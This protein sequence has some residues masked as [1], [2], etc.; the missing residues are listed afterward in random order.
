M[1]MRTRRWLIQILL[2]NQTKISV[3]SEISTMRTTVS[4]VCNS[5]GSTG[6]LTWG[7]CLIYEI[8]QPLHDVPDRFIIDRSSRPMRQPLSCYYF[9]QVGCRCCAAQGGCKAIR[10]LVEK[11]NS[12][13]SRYVLTKS[14]GPCLKL[15]SEFGVDFYQIQ[16]TK[17]T[18]P[19]RENHCLQLLLDRA[20]PSTRYS[21]DVD[22]R[23]EPPSK[24]KR[25]EN[26]Q[27][28]DGGRIVYLESSVDE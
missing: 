18:D 12:Q 19:D 28:F 23:W 3:S 20:R 1:S 6:T 10:R 17:V 5:S 27:V 15:T 24:I 7:I 4:M 9:L 13:G 11:I 25:I 16:K 26:V 21:R 8:H 22:P 2:R 14:L